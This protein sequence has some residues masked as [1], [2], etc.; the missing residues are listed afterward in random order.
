MA[1]APLLCHAQEP[2]AA[3]LPPQQPQIAPL[4]D[5]SALG[6]QA[7]LQAAVTFEAKR[8]KLADVLAALQAQSG[9]T[10]TIAPGSPLA[11]RLLTARAKSMPL[12][13]VLASLSRLYGAAWAKQGAAFEMRSN[14]R[15][16]IES[17]AWKLPSTF[18]NAFKAAQAD[19]IDWDQEVANLGVD[20]LRQKGGVALDELPED[21]IQKLRAQAEA[22]DVT[23]LG[24]ELDKLRLQNL[25][26]ATLKVSDD[27][28]PKAT[29]I[30]MKLF[31]PGEKLV[32]DYILDAAPDAK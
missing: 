12:A 30:R 21:I 15:S 6:A 1:S 24:V 31:L 17:T 22:R 4:L 19:S 20:R 14:E 32:G 11:S 26:G 18:T 23:Q 3:T 8:Q 29:R 9:V 2:Q 7:E 27:S 13:R 25:T 5:E 10:L 28:T 16:D